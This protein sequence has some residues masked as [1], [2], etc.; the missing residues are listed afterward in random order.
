MKLINKLFIHSA[1]S[2]LCGTTII[3]IAI[4]VQFIYYPVD[5]F[6]MQTSTDIIKIF[7]I[8]GYSNVGIGTIALL[9]YYVH[10]YILAYQLTYNIYGFDM[11]KKINILIY[12]WAG[13]IISASI[14]YLFNNASI[15]NKNTIICIIISRIYFNRTNIRLKYITLLN[16]LQIIQI[17]ELLKRKYKYINA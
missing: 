5:I 13:C 12:Y 3:S 16:I 15:N 17:P 8:I 11:L 1:V 10:D 7:I 14:I 4:I 9:S 6:S 2:L